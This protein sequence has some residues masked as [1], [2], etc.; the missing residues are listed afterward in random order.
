[1]WTTYGLGPGSSPHTRGAQDVRLAGILLAGIIPAYAGSTSSLYGAKLINWDH[2]RIRGEHAKLMLNSC[3]GKGSSP[4][5]RGAPL[6]YV[7]NMCS[8]GIIPAYAGS[9]LPNPPHYRDGQDHPRIRGEHSSRAAGSPST[10]GSSPHTRG[11]QAMCGILKLVPGIIPAYA[12]ST[13]TF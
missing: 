3:S 9:T 6:Y 10:P 11:A 7:C 12:G 4:H 13:L 1:M 8:Y 5:T 2:P